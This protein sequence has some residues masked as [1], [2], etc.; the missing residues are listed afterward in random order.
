MANQM[1]G[2]VA[3]NCFRVGDAYIWSEI[4]YLDSPTDYREYLPAGSATPMAG[5]GDLVM[6]DDSRPG[7]KLFTVFSAAV[8]MILLL[9]GYLLFLFSKAL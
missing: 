5:R 7:Y 4:Y 8:A 6:T 3:G 1:N 9:L 2:S